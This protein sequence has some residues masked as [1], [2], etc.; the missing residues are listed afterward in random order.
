MPGELRTRRLSVAT[1]NLYLGADLA[2]LF[3]VPRPTSSPARGGVRASWSG[4]TSRSG[5]RRSPGSWPASRSTSSGSRRCRAGPPRRCRPRG[6]SGPRRSRRLPADA[7][8]RAGGGGPPYEVHAV[9]AASPAACRSTGRW[10]SS[11]RQRR[12]GPRGGRF[13]SRPSAPGPSTPAAPGHRDRGSH[14]P[15]PAAG[16]GRGARSPAAAGGRQHAHRGVGRGVRDAQRDELLAALGEPGARWS[17][18]AT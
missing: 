9:N 6:R 4:P 18:S 17:C 8:R 10:M 15:T 1:Y 11:R 2:L 5:P 13:P 12:P 7:A 3:G 16:L 14:L